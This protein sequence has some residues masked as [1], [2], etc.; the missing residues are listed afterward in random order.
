M[1]GAILFGPGVVL[2][3]GTQGGIVNRR[4]NV[5]V[6]L[7]ALSLVILLGATACGK[8][9]DNA[10]SGGDTVKFSS[11]ANG[12]SVTEPF[13]VKIDS[14]VPL[15][16]PGTGKHHVHLCFDGKS[17]DSEYSLVYGNTFTIKDL[18]SG[19]HT[20]EA[21]L[22][23][24]DHSAAGATATITVNVTG[25]GATSSPTASSSGGGYSYH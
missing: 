2:P 25:G 19:Q 12:A 24:A 18:S 14:S 13:E 9:S 22:R 11:P 21:S 1:T 17:C 20:I 5:K 23:N 10:G 4:P 15:G 7:A 8:K 6:G 16:D 3:H